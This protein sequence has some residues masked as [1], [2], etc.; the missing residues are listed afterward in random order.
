MA[1]YQN[2]ITGLSVVLL[3][4]YDQS[5]IATDNSFE[6][7]GNCCV[8]TDGHFGQEGNSTGQEGGMELV[9]G[10]KLALEWTWLSA[11]IGDCKLIENQRCFCL[12]YCVAY[13]HTYLHM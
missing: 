7:Y 9:E 3:L 4:R 12:V 11:W 6:D 5:N 8:P 2:E 10:E 1:A 13:I